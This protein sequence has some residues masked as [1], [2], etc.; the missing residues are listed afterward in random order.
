MSAT[1]APLTSG[2]FTETPFAAIFAA[3]HSRPSTTW[4]RW[5]RLGL[6]SL[7]LV[8]QGQLL[9]HE[10]D[11]LDHGDRGACVLCAHGPGQAAVPSTAAPFLAEAHPHGWR[12]DCAASF[13]P[14]RPAP[15]FGARAPPRI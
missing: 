13:V 10:V 7:L 4:Q 2:L 9:A 11:H 6:L 14:C 15:A 8:L 12:A 1:L 3:M 5:F